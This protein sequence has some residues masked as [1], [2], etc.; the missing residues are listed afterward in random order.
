MKA[1]PGTLVIISIGAVLLLAVTGAM[2]KRTKP[3]N[4][5]SSNKSKGI[6]GPTPRRMPSFDVKLEVGKHYTIEGTSPTTPTPTQMSDMQN[7]PGVGLVLVEHEGNP[8]TTAST[9]KDSYRVTIDI[10]P[11]YALDVS[12]SFNFEGIILSGVSVKK[13]D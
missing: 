13:H 3:L 8:L 7:H 2:A 11:T 10:T 6:V 9:G 12:T 4:A 1:G 5:V